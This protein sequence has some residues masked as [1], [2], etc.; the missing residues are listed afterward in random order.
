[1]MLM[2]SGNFAIQSCSA[3]ALGRAPPKEP[4]GTLSFRAI[5]RIWGRS[6]HRLEGSVRSRAQ[7]RAARSRV[8]R[9]VPPGHP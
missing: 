5:A 9:R 8:V 3:L 6:L 7:A 1:M 2:A 4:P